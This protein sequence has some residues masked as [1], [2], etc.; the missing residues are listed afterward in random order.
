MNQTTETYFARR[1]HGNHKVLG[2]PQGFEVFWPSGSV[3]YPS[4]RQTIIA[5]VNG[6]PTPDPHARDP[7]LTF[8]RYFK[9]GRFASSP[10]YLKV[11]ALDMFKLV[12][13]VPLTVD[14]PAK[15][16]AAPPI[17]V[18][19]STLGIDLDARGHEVRKLFFAGFLRRV[20][21]LGYDPEEMLQEIYKGILIRNR[22]KCPFDVTKSSFG[23]YVHM[24]AGCIISNYHRKQSRR[25]HYEL[26][27][28]TGVDGD[29]LDVSEADIAI[30]E[31][32]TDDYAAGRIARNSILSTVGDRAR[33]VGHDPDLSIRCAELAMEGFQKSEIAARVGETPS[34][35]GKTLRIVR[36]AA[37]EWDAEQQF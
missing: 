7:K 3:K 28:V 17:T 2:T 21:R 18:A 14:R 25:N 23:H 12:Q 37:R 6:T 34:L 27:G 11:D 1:E 4:A 5:L 29:L 22:G 9:R 20:L 16:K 15:V 30:A 10:S 36:K 19:A 35:V 33:D 26:F 13:E 24:V 8:D 32:R 31:D